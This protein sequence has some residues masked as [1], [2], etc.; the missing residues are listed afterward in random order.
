MIFA[1]CIFSTR[2]LFMEGRY[3]LFF[4][5]CAKKK[6]KNRKKKE[7]IFLCECSKR[8]DVGGCAHYFW[9]DITIL[10]ELNAIYS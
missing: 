1:F 4:S 8:C 3:A 2:G 5:H 9:Y 10:I 7:K 6:F